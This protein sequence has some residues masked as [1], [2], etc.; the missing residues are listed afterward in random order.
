MTQSNNELCSTCAAA[1]YQKLVYAPTTTPRRDDPWFNTPLGSL[2]DIISRS[3]KCPV[4]SLMVDSLR[5]QYKRTP[6]ENLPYA[7]YT[8]KPFPENEREAIDSEVERYGMQ[9]TLDGKDIMCSIELQYFCEVR[10]NFENMRAPERKDRVFVHRL[11]LALEPNPYGTLSFMATDWVRLQVIW[12]KEDSNNGPDEFNLKGRLISRQGSGRQVGEYL[13][14]SLVKGWLDQCEKEH[15]GTCCNPAWLAGSDDPWLEPFRAIDVKERRVVNL[16]PQSRYIALSYVWGATSQTPEERAQRHLASDNFPRITQVNGLDELYLPKTVEDAIELTS[17]MGERYLWVDALCIIQDD[18]KD[19]SH[20]TARMDL[21]YSRAL[22]TIIAAC[23]DDS[24]AGLSGLPGRGRD[25]Y[26]R[27]VCIS[28]EGFHLATTAGLY[29]N[30]PLERSTWNTRGWTF[31][32]R[33]LSRR[34]MVFTPYQVFWI[35]E[36]AMWDEEVILEGPKPQARVL[37]LAFGC[38]DEWDDG[39]PKFSREALATYTLQFSLRD[40]TFSADVLPAFLG[41]VRRYEHLNND[42]IHWGIPTGL[43][44]QS[45]TWKSGNS[46]REEM[47]RVVCGDGEVQEVKYP[48]WSWL[49]WTGMIS[50]ILHNFQLWEKTVKREAGAELVFYRLLSDGEVRL[51]EEPGQAGDSGLKWKG[52]SVIKG[53]IST[54]DLLVS[55]MESIGISETDKQVT[56]AYDT[57]RLVFWTSHAVAKAR[58]RQNKLLLHIQDQV[59]ELK[60]DFSQSFQ[61]GFPREDDGSSLK[62][63]E[64][65]QRVDLIFISRWY[66]IADGKETGKLNVLLVEQSAG[67]SIWSRAGVA[68][69][70]ETDWIHLEP[71]W[72]MVILG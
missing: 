8:G 49:G 13:N 48:S 35:C 16:P 60:A 32:E 44:D 17:K 39:D 62:P 41:V 71:N 55:K 68:V 20:Q 33:I 2:K 59:L 7:F 63:V 4:C 30:A 72:E 46:R 25:I 54:D 51:I 36:D 70:E 28:P 11:L 19:L 47:H 38:N 34:I 6:K 45:I 14:F 61:D 43:F 64:E 65:A 9:V 57:G 3:E 18:I 5:E 22:F 42:R 24:E 52:E 12:S 23:G 27:S 10:E 66:E 26:Q 1:D 31:Q 53:P 21:V 15:G 29:V 58:F 50:P 56:P 37:S 67:S 40:F 69:I